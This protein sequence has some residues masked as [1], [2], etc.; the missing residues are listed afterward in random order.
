MRANDERGTR[1][2]GQQNGNGH[3][4]SPRIQGHACRPGKNKK[5][6]IDRKDMAQADVEMAPNGED[7]VDREQNPERGHAT[8]P[9]SI[10][11]VGG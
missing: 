5:R 1:F 8:P 7:P 6:R 11:R 9:A 2:P 3:Y 10:V 4:G